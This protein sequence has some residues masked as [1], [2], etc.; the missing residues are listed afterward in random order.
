MELQDF[1]DH[2]N[3][4]ELIEGGSEQ[5]RFMHGAAQEALRNVAELNSGYRTPEEVRTLLTRLTGR[6]VDESVAVFPPL[7]SEFGKTGYDASPS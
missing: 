4:G 5:H 3:R 7:Y 1:L 2:V 6:T